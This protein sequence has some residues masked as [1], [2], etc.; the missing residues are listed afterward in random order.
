MWIASGC[1]TKTPRKAQP[2]RP[3]RPATQQ[4]D[5]LKSVQSQGI[6]IHWQ[7]EAPDGKVRR[8]LE[9]HAASG[10]WNVQTLSGILKAGNGILYRDD[11]PKVRFQAPIVEAKRSLGILVARGGVVL[12]SIDPAGATVTANRVRWDARK[13]LVV[14]VGNV[15]LTYR[16]PGSAKPVAFGT[17]PQM[18]FNTEL[19]EYHIP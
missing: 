12:H 19:D 13:N 14:A 6:V 4:A 8:V 1:G 3:P 5:A 9:L 18:T 10:Q 11:M 17:A 2:K 15:R 16:P 7:E